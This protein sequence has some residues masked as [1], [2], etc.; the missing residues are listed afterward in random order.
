MLVQVPTKTTSFTILEYCKAAIKVW[1]S[2]YNAF[3]S[4][5]SIGVLYSQLGVETGLSK[6]CYCYNLGNIKAIDIP[7]ETIKYC[8]LKGVWEIVNGKRVTLTPDNPGSWFRAFDTL[9]EGMSFYINF[10]RNKRYKIAWA[11]VEGGDTLKF[12]T[13]LKQQGYYTA[14]VNDYAKIMQYYFTRFMKDNTFEL[15]LSAVNEEMNA[16]IEKP[17]DDMIFNVKED[18]IDRPSP[19]P[20]ED[21]EKEIKSAFFISNIWNKIQSYLKK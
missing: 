4:K 9:D 14:P 11:G 5:Q 17:V 10:L 8:A 20:V 15:A 3:P 2:I 1:F 6:N 12:A 13:L 16:N 18:I 19:I 7:G 21:T